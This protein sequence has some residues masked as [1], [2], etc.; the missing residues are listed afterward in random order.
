MIVVFLLG[1]ISGPYDWDPRIVP[2]QILRLNNIFILCVPA[3]FT[4]MA[5][6]RLRKAMKAILDPLAQT[7]S[8][9]EA[10]VTIAGLCNTYS[11]YVTTFEEYQAQRYEAASTIYG[12][13]TLTGYIQEFSRLAK[14][15][16]SGV[17]SVTGEAPPDLRDG[18]VGDEH[19]CLAEGDLHRLGG[20][21]RG[22]G[23]GG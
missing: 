19:V 15:M 3:E 12:P 11:S 13:H 5:G 16:V 21:R 6:R 2:L 10:V 17:P 9:K 22:E 4:T 18:G 1:D 8:F 7:D 20:C 23:R 14:D